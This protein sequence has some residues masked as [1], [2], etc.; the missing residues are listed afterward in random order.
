MNDS[1]KGNSIDKK[2]K[3]GYPWKLLAI[4]VILFIITLPILYLIPDAI[5]C[6]Y[7]LIA[8]LIILGCAICVEV[9]Q[10]NPNP[11]ERKGVA[12]F[13]GLIGIIGILLSWFIWRSVIHPESARYVCLGAGIGASQFTGVALFHYLRKRNLIQ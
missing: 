5:L 12:F 4:W 9:L 6:L 10:L 1:I 8:S 7:M 3:P 11:V 13:I 2:A